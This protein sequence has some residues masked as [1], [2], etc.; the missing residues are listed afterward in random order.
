[1]GQAVMPEEGGR[2]LA[3][4]FLLMAQ[5]FNVLGTWDMFVFKLSSKARSKCNL[6]K[7]NFL[8]YFLP[9][10]GREGSSPSA[11]DLLPYEQAR[12]TCSCADGW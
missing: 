9:E 1:M 5:V 11:S 3:D 6:L 4:R 10:M 12:S 2:Q 8:F 7:A